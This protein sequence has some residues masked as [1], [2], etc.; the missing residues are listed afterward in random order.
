MRKACWPL[1]YLA[2]TS[3]S[4]PLARL[5]DRTV[6]GSKKPILVLTYTF[7]AYLAGVIVADLVLGS[8]FA[9]AK[10]RPENV[11][12]APRSSHR[13]LDQRY[14]VQRIMVQDRFKLTSISTTDKIV[15][16]HRNFAAWNITRSP[17]TADIPFERL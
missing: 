5:S 12:P 6:M 14:Q 2:A 15:V 17:A 1:L 9:P 16:G 11:A 4:L 3:L 10:P 8:F 7:L 13:Q